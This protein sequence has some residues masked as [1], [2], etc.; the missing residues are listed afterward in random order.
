MEVGTLC[1]FISWH[2]RDRDHLPRQKLL[3]LLLCVKHWFWSNLS[4]CFDCWGDGERSARLLPAAGSA[5]QPSP[6]LCHTCH[7]LTRPHTH[8]HTHVSGRRVFVRFVSGAYR[9]VNCALQLFSHS[10]IQRL[11]VTN[12]HHHTFPK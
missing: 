5:L 3:F 8:T 7:G 2:Q 6:V 12:A 9:F 11:Q 10:G 1:S 4:L